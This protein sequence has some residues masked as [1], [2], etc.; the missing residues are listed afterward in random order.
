M[1]LT[2]RMS[3]S[4][5][6]SSLSMHADAKLSLNSAYHQQLSLLDSDSYRQS[7]RLEV[8]ESPDDLDTNDGSE[9]FERDQS[10]HTVPGSKHQRDKEVVTCTMCGKAYK[11]KSCLS[12]HLWEHHEF[13]N[14]AKKFCLSKH[15]QV[16]LMEAAQTLVDMMDFTSKKSLA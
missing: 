12:K 14:A 15:Q 4:D 13:W 9:S 8:P 5:A 2:A 3:D 1:A 11:H 10:E 16:Q 6:V 7:V